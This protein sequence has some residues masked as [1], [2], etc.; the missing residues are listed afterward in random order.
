MW[1]PFSYFSVKYENH[2]N[3]IQLVPVTSDASTQTDEIVKCD[4]KVRNLF[5]LEKAVYKSYGKNYV[6]AVTFK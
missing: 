4:E 5:F 1:N 3:C 2:E 6:D